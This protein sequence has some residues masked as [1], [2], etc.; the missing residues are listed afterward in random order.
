MTNPPLGRYSQHSNKKFKVL[1]G[2]EGVCFGVGWERPKDYFRCSRAIYDSRKF[3]ISLNVG[4]KAKQQGGGG[5]GGILMFRISLDYCHYPRTEK[6]R[7]ISLMFCMSQL[8]H[9]WPRASS[10][11]QTDFRLPKDVEAFPMVP[12]TRKKKKRLCFDLVK[13]GKHQE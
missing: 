1:V 11:Y 5:G 7:C 6:T 9:H 8:S 4:R 3:I 10:G 12:K 13:A 2:V